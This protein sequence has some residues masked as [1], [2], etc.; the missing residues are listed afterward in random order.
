MFNT[1]KTP[2][3]TINSRNPRATQFKDSCVIRG[4]NT[5]SLLNYT[6]V[7]QVNSNCL[8]P[9]LNFSCANIVS[10]IANKLSAL[11]SNRANIVSNVA[12]KLSALNVTAQRTISNATASLQPTIEDVDKTVEEIQVVNINLA[13]I[14]RL[15]EEAKQA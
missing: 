6:K 3:Y 2:K 5:Y 4:N 10:N 14:V 9:N 1:Y 11:N 7:D 12:S 13:E 8:R 15:R